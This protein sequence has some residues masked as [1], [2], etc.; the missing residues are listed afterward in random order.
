M[1]IPSLSQVLL[2]AAALAAVVVAAF[3]WHGY[4]KSRRMP[5]L[6]VHKTA[7]TLFAKRPE[8]G[9]NWRLLKRDRK[10]LPSE[11]RISM[12]NGI[13]VAVGYND[14]GRPAHINEYAAPTGEAAQHLNVMQDALEVLPRLR[15]TEIRDGYGILAQQSF[16]PDGS[17]KTSVKRD[18]V[19]NLEVTTYS[20]TDQSVES[21]EIF[22]GSQNV[23]SNGRGR[24][25]KNGSPLIKAV[26]YR[27][28]HSLIAVVHRAALPGA[29]A[30]SRTYIARDNLRPDGTL[31]TRTYFL[32]SW[33]AI[34]YDYSADGL[35]ALHSYAYGY[36]QVTVAELD[37]QTRKMTVQRTYRADGED[38]R[39]IDVE[40]V[41]K[42]TGARVTQN[43]LK[44]QSIG[45]AVKGSKPQP[46]N[47]RIL[48]QGYILLSAK[49]QYPEGHNPTSYLVQYQYGTRTIRTAMYAI[50]HFGMLQYG[51][52]PDGSLDFFEWVKME[53]AFARGLNKMPPGRNSYREPKVP[54]ALTRPVPLLPLPLAEM[55]RQ[56]QPLNTHEQ[57][58]RLPK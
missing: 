42:A 49:I 35:T 16:R 22:D 7:S 27:P 29:E 36:S 58:Y 38:Q 48:N 44:P 12:R 39:A 28:D 5:F 3:A 18:D 30:D 11:M 32:S 54:E 17:V 56:P 24:G 8:S 37:P 4:E 1:K 25:S 10:G 26:Y 15:H 34:T 46:I 51:Y 9:Q 47:P 50:A 31:D 57:T 45:R 21:V 20:D 19:Y 40:F 41:D 6:E 2:T 13:T 53:G 14:A 43:W 55:M 33:Q 23:V 52:R